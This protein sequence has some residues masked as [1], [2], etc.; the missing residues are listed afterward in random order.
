MKCME[1]LNIIDIKSKNIYL[2]Y[3]KFKLNKCI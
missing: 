3:I 2:N 1:I